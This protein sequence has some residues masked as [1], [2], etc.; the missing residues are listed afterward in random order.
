MVSIDLQGREGKILPAEVR[1][2]S[3]QNARFVAIILSVIAVAIV[4]RI[5]ADAKIRA[6]EDAMID[7]FKAQTAALGASPEKIEQMA[8][9]FKSRNSEPH[10]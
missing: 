3:E 2:M 4:N 7:W 8:E 5:L 10:E 9:D 6:L 1:E